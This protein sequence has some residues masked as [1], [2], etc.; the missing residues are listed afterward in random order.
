MAD[1]NK[2]TKKIN[3]YLKRRI[4]RTIASVLLVTAIIVAALPTP[5]IEADTP[6]PPPTST[7]V[8]TYPEES[9]ITAFN[10][11]EYKDKN[12][13]A[14]ASLIETYEVIRLNNG[15][16]QLINVFTIYLQGG[17]GVICDFNTKYNPEGG[18][19]TIPNNVATDY[20]Q[21]TDAEVE[22]YIGTLTSANEQELNAYLN[23]LYDSSL[24]D[25]AGGYSDDPYKLTGGKWINQGT[26]LELST[27]DKHSYYLETIG[28]PR[29]DGWVSK[30]VIVET[31]GS[32]NIRKFIP[33]DTDDNKWKY[34]TDYSINA[35]ADNAFYDSV[36]KTAKANH[37]ENLNLQIQDNIVAIG[38]EAF[39]GASTLKEMTIGANVKVIGDR[40][41]KGCTGLEKLVIN[42]GNTTI[43]VE[44]FSI[45][46]SLK[47]V[48]MPASFK[49]IDVGGFSNCSELEVVDMTAATDDDII[50][51]DYA[52][53]GCGN[54]REIKFAPRTKT[55]GD[56]CFALTSAFNSLEVIE[57]PQTSPNLIEL[58][59]N[60]FQ[61]QINLREVTMPYFMG[62]KTSIN[63]AAGFFKGCEN[64]EIV[65]F[66][67][68]SI[69]VSFDDNLFEDVTNPLIRVIGPAHISAGSTDKS[70]Y[71]KPRV[72]AHAANIPYQYEYEDV[73]YLELKYG[74]EFYRIN[75]DGKL[76]S[77]ESEVASDV[78]FEVFEQI[79]NYKLTGIDTECFDDS[80]KQKIT[81]VTIHDG[82]DLD[83]DPNAFES[84]EELLEVYV[85]DA[86]EKIGSSAFSGCDKLAD[87][88]IGPS[89]NFIGNSAFLDCRGI[90]EIEFISDAGQENIVIEPDAFKTGSTE[91]T[92]TGHIVEG[93]APFEWAMDDNNYLD[94][95][96]KRVC[97]K[98]PAPANLTVLYDNNTD[99][100]T[101]VDYPHF[102]NIDKD[103]PK[104]KI[105]LYENYVELINTQY[106]S[107][108]AKRDAHIGYIQNL[109]GISI[110]SHG[111]PVISSA[112]NY[113]IRNKINNSM[114]ETSAIT[115][116][117]GWNAADIGNAEYAQYYKT[118]TDEQDLYDNIININVKA[119]IESID[120]RRY[121][122]AEYNGGAE[123]NNANAD[124]LDPSMLALYI[125]PADV[126][127]DTACVGNGKLKLIDNI[128]Y[129]ATTGGIT[130]QQ[131]VFE[132]VPSGLFSGN[133]MEYR[134]SA[135]DDDE[136]EKTLRGNDRI[137][138][139]SLQ[140]V[141]ELPDYAFAGCEGL[142]N[143]YI[144]DG[145]EKSGI[146][147]FLGANNSD[148]SVDNDKFIAENKIL[149]EK[150][151]DSE[152]NVAHKIVQALPNR[153]LKNGAE[154][155]VSVITD[156]LLGTT[157]GM[158]EEAFIDTD[159]LGSVD[160]ST[161]RGL[162]TVPRRAF[163]DS[164]VTSVSLPNTVGVI[165]DQAF[166]TQSY[167]TTTIPTKNVNISDD[168]FNTAKIVTY[169]DSSAYNYAKSKNLATALLGEIF[170][171][172]FMDNLGNL[173]EEQEVSTGESAYPPENVKAPEG[174]VF[175]RWNG[176]FRN[177]TQNEL[178]FAIFKDAT[179]SDSDGDGDDDDQDEDG[180]GVIDGTKFKVTITS[181]SGSGSYYPGDIVNIVANASADKRIFDKWTTTSSGAYL[182][183]DED[184]AT[185]F[186]M[187]K[188]DVTIVAN[189]KA[190]STE[191]SG[192]NGNSGG[193]ASDNN[194]TTNPGGGTTLITISK[195]GFSDKNVASAYVNGSP[196]NFVVKITESQ[197][198]KDKMTEA[199]ESELDSLESIVFF[200]MDITLYDKSGTVKVT[201]TADITVTITVP[202]PDELRKYGG[203]NRVA[204]ESD[205]EL[206][207]LKPK[208]STIN[209]IPCISFEASHFSPYAIYV[210]VDNLGEGEA[211]DENPKTGDGIHPKWFISIGLLGVSLYLF[212]KRD[213]RQVVREAVVK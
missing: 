176:N 16:Y 204:C 62:D 74:S 115:A 146:A 109:I 14:G 107:D 141:K 177:V 15:E 48:V 95:Y 97:Y 5:G 96:G 35:I 139:I 119:G 153:G 30:E 8:V 157:T 155:E 72:S 92:I 23:I 37:I 178:V 103:N 208:F 142:T 210:D 66:G 61:G 24:N 27:K 34:S 152:G 70:N 184:V 64:L 126:P 198:A 164:G 131:D 134:P 135:T 26:G 213:R 86:V 93:Y 52:F 199:F 39:R 33:Y 91:L 71:A 98:S 84:A 133:F 41:F 171:V 112:P 79:G 136:N 168:V 69:N 159:G 80:T 151:T 88:S 108:I 130:V 17:S 105:D 156:P 7:P 111:E 100:V 4:R 57:F 19:L 60:L 11:S 121:F 113:Y 43:G 85:G 36:S 87:V 125:E 75:S 29:V 144:G 73:T 123:N 137:K 212:M 132:H 78:H 67:E 148:V 54:L 42:A 207:K 114:G 167:V 170:T 9:A 191:G 145:L 120:V 161:C 81:K 28:C 206:E 53:Y 13:T 169:K 22:A 185:S 49:K 82:V 94:V 58:G 172:K 51:E 175:D 129:L 179:D 12:T 50:L 180:D 1:N 183:N 90:T 173:I 192:N 154:K 193:S 32:G 143:V 149:Y 104:A 174:M 117:T 55:I 166:K 83:I 116:Y 25:G 182:F 181:G 45:C 21:F 147:P 188:N 40:A 158:Y 189:Y 102:K 187:P 163:Y 203:N 2:K 150:I 101:L 200:P 196:D 65:R 44:S 127:L 76:I 110:N 63:I 211:T 138:T 190:A 106:A 162:I 209:G 194:V 99:L 3:P 195:P 10:P 6:T 197:Y 31:S 124:Y 165:E 18:I 20:M 186:V 77:F 56:A 47:K 160:L 59:E 89:V 140:G 122:A 38:T 46:N 128:Q 68:R 205:G 202:I 118:T 201:D